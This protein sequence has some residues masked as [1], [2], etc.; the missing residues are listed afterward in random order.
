MSKL[1]PKPF[2]FPPLQ[3]R[4]P[5]LVAEAERLLAQGKIDAGVDRLGAALALDANS[6]EA[7]NLMGIVCVMRSD[8]T[9]ATRHA[10]TATQAQPAKPQN[11]FTLGRAF[12]LGGSLPEAIAAYRRAVELDPHYAEARVSLGIALGHVGELD[13]A[14]EQHQQ[15]LRIKPELAAAHA[16]LAKALAARVERSI[17]A[18]ND[19]APSEEALNALARAVQ[20]DPRNP[21]LH[22]NHGLLLSG[23]QRRLDAA[24]AFQRALSLDITDVESCLRLGDCLRAVGENALTRELYE[25]WLGSNPP[26]AAVMRAFSSWLTRIGAVDEA[27]QW[28]HKALALDPDPMTLLQMG[29]SLMQARRVGEALAMGRRAIEASGRNANF[30]PASLLGCNYLVEDAKAIFDLHAEYGRSL[31]PRTRSRRPRVELQAG[32]RLKVGYVSGDFI[33]HSVASFV[34]ALFERHDRERFEVFLYHNRGYRDAVTDRFQALGHHWFDCDGLS[35]EALAR[36]IAADGVDILVDLAGHT[37]NSRSHMFTLAPA[38]LQLSYLGYPTI[39]GV[40][41]IDFRITDTVIDPGDMPPLASELPLALPR[42][43]FCFRPDQMTPDIGPC[44]SLRNG[45]VTFGS[46]N[47]IAKVNDHTLALWAAA[48]NAVPGS[49]LLLKSGAMAQEV[50]RQSVEKVMASHGVAGDRLTLT[51]WV[52]NKGGHLKLYNDIDIALDPYPYNGAT[53]TCEA[54]WMGVPVVSRCGATHTSRMGASILRAAGKGEWVASSDD[55]F[56]AIAAKVAAEEDERARWRAIGRESLR[57]CELLDEAGFTQAFEA[58]LL[59]AWASAGEHQF[60]AI[61]A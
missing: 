34:G 28:G 48:M 5:G 61:A 6:A 29:G 45:Y 32:Q 47:N 33:S 2:N 51:A 59:Q 1:K 39:S 20:F 50:N 43:M 22:R 49:R 54:L 14:I 25:K 36:R 26:N 10:Q 11:W 19:E 56:V 41:S 17:Q 55:S 57:R 8:A 4:L 31:P 35:D 13:E 7:H 3:S 40:P 24:D 60:G 42:S 27:L 38:P 15:A 46:F 44:P 9:Q 37:E 12:K 53:T 18:G 30:Y 23:A 16:N 21:V 52:V 58:A